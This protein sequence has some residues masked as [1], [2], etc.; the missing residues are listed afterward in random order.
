[1]L[2]LLL[3]VG[4]VNNSNPSSCSRCIHADAALA[5]AKVHSTSTALNLQAVCCAKLKQL[6][7]A[8][9]AAAALAALAARLSYQSTERIM[10]Y[11]QAIALTG[12]PL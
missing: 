4:C 10:L 6:A 11:P 9:A 8:A 1:M 3:A 5:A 12:T 7:A 2:L